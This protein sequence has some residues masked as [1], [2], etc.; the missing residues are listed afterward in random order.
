MDTPK[1]EYTPP[2]DG[3]LLYKYRHLEGEHRDW[4]KRI[5]T[6]SV[7]YLSSAKS[8]NDPFDSRVRFRLR[9]NEQKI[10][11]YFDSVLKR[12]EPSLSR[13]HR[14]IEVQK[15][16]N[17]VKKQ[18]V[19]GVQEKIQD[20]IDKK[21]GILSL[22]EDPNN[23]LL[24]GHYANAHTGLCLGFN[25]NSSFFR[26]AIKVIY[27]DEYVEID[28][29][30]VDDTYYRLLTTKAKAWQYER[31][32]RIIYMNGLGNKN[33]SQDA[34]K[35]IILG[36]RMPD[37]DKNDVLSWVSECKSPITILQA[38]PSNTEFKMT[39]SILR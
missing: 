6:D 20:R 10:K 25:A 39:F 35:V 33:Y 17:R 11:K 22:S 29:F 13:G 2:S 38:Q 5:I 34:L 12:R 23:I 4:T 30:I 28:P 32:R 31:E 7:V 21:L 19:I 9:A 24:W 26:E 1:Q 36:Y 16:I 3:S 37:N 27:Q 14:R 15:M 8:F 18:G